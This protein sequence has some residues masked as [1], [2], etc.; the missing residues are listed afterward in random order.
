MFKHRAL[1]RPIAHK[2][3]PQVKQNV[4]MPTQEKD[5]YIE[6]G[7]DKNMEKEGGIERE[8]EKKKTNERKRE[9]EREREIE[10]RKNEKERKTKKETNREEER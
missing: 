6:K 3:T 5:V 10:R 9:R 2:Q 4:R 1:Y 8:R 7:T